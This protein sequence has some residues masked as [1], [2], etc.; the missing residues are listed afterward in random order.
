MYAPVEK[1]QRN[2]AVRAPRRD[3]LR[4]PVTH[5]LKTLH[6]DIVGPL[7]QVGNKRFVIT[8][9]DRFTRWVEAV[10]VASHTAEVIVDTIYQ[11]WIVRYGVPRTIV[12]DQGA[13]FESYEF[14]RFLKYM[15]IIRSRTTA[16]HPQANGMIERMHATLKAS[17]RCMTETGLSWVKALPTCLMGLRTA[18]S[19][20]GVSPSLVLYGEQIT[21]PGMIV[22]HVPDVEHATPHELV[23]ELQKEAEVMRE[24]ILA[25]DQTLGGTDTPIQ[26]RMPEFPT[27]YV[28][29]REAMDK[30][31]LNPKYRGPYKIWERKGPNLIITRNGKEE[32][33]SADR[34]K[35][36]Y[37]LNYPALKISKRLKDLPQTDM[38]D[39]SHEGLNKIADGSLP[40]E[41]AVMR[42]TRETIKKANELEPCVVSLPKLKLNKNVVRVTPEGKIIASILNK[43]IVNN[44]MINTHP[45]GKI[46]SKS[47]FEKYVAP[48]L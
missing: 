17:L 38:D 47:C 29:I 5:R 44:H 36:Y 20:W 3:Y 16:Y 6:I 41:N 33:I 42:A 48:F 13:E 43:N 8:M 12:T 34:C 9:I 28:L 7:I 35:P 23:N 10:P 15:G 4:F 14:D 31:S 39:Q 24:V 22:H 45:T 2:K 11:Y 19:D 32:R 1:C 18:V 40:F 37:T 30:G 46:R 21:I 25:N 26:P 27:E